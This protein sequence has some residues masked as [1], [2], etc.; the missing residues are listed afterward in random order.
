MSYKSLKVFG[1]AYV[2]SLNPS[3]TMMN[4]SIDVNFSLSFV[5]KL[6]GLP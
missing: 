2:I 6:G 3:Y 1:F 5:W 4:F